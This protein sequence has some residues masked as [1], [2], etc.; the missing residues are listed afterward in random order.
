MM[1]TVR[2]LMGFVIT[3]FIISVL[4]FFAFELIPGDPAVQRLGTDATE[5]SLTQLREEMGLNRPILIRYGS[6]F[7]GV[8]AGNLGDSFTF[9][10]PVAQL[11]TDRMPITITLMI[12]SFVMIL[13]LSIP[14]SLL[15]AR[16]KG[17]MFD[18][19]VLA[20]N[21]ITMSI[22]A[23]FVGMIFTFFFGLVLRWFVPGG[24]VSF[25]TNVPAFLLYLIL[26]S[27]AIALPRAAMTSKILRN[28]LIDEL[29][30]DY[31]RTALSRGSGL[32]RVLIH[33]V[34]KN[35]MLPIITFLGLTLA[36]IV[37]N[38]IIIERVFGIPGLGTLFL[39]SIATRDYPVVKAVIFFLGVF[40]LL[41]NLAADIIYTRLDK[42]IEV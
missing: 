9:Q 28:S 4:I 41:L 23:F 15:C 17:S 31:V 34:F 29:S 19:I 21:Q 10:V 12:M 13:I 2:K 27:L 36:D 38:S 22:P 25:Q 32:T 3:L 16:W 26:P 7:M 8:F 1:Y 40:I 35:G 24:Y 20:C 11:L 39:Q 6:W 14:I 33:H 30:K 18:S 5:E 37:T 42:R